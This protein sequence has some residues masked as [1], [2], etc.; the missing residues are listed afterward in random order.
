MLFIGHIDD[1]MMLKSVK[2]SIFSDSIPNL[3]YFWGKA[4]LCAFEFKWNDRKANAKCPATFAKA[5]PE[6]Q[7]KVITPQSIDEFLMP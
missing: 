6:A 7:F 1:F 4:R 2:S 3:L 5:Y